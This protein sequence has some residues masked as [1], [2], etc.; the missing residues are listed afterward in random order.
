MARSLTRWA[1][2]GLF[3]MS[4]LWSGGSVWRLAQSPAGAWLV[5]RARADLDAAFARA[6]SRHAT[7]HALAE[8]VTRHLA[9]TPRNWVALDGLRDL[10]TSRNL[11][12][13][14]DVAAAL[15]QARAQD[16]GWRMRAA[17]CA[18]C[19]HD[20]RACGLGPDLVC[21]AAVSMTVAGDI[22]ALTREGAAHLRGEDVDQVDV[23][24]S[25]IGLGATALVVASGGGSYAVKGGAGFL[26]LAHRTGRLAPDMLAVLRRAFREGVD[27]AHL[28][29]H[30]DIRAAARMD[31]LRPALALAGDMGALQARLGTGGALHMLRAAQTGAELRT[32]ARA[33]DALGPQSVGALEIL[34]KSRFLRTSLRVAPDLWGLIAGLAG[35]ALSLLAA[36]GTG[37][38]GRIL[39][40]RLTAVIRPAQP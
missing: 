5:D 25:L 33:T 1:L 8:A 20:L 10:A 23:T 21:G 16:F 22:M 6:L 12:L 29:R 38:A 14:P 7:P 24:L 40:A 37:L 30:R 34:G 28:A 4:L 39:R 26:K 18:L 36:L 32:I 15:A 17:R 35:M 27:W 13:P 2:T 19:A 9:S 3:I 31:A 11:T